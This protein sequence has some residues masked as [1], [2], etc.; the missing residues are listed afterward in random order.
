MNRTIWII[1]V[2]VVL[3]L[4]VGASFYWGTLYGKSQVQTAVPAMP[5]LAPGAMPGAMPGA[6]GQGG[7]TGGANAPAGMTFGQIESIKG[8]TLMLT[9]ANNREIR[10]QVTDTTLIERNASVTVSELEVGETVTI[11]GSQNDDGSISARS[12]QVNPAGRFGGSQPPPA[13]GG[14]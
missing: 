12:V 11:S 7:A 2:A 3:V 13:G 10:V 9:D 5:D 8:D 1:L 14:Q 4:V 6:G